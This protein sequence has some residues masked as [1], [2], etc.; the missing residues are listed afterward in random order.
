ME[1]DI[2][3]PK[4]I[5]KPFYILSIDGGGFRGLFAA[6]LLR[7]MEEEWQ[8]DWRNRFGLMA[9]TSTGAILA[10]GL[11]CEK[12]AVQLADFYTTHA[13]TIF[14]PRL[15]SRYD[16]LK[17]FTSRYSSKSLKT[18]LEATL[19][20]ITLGQL[21]IPL[22]L[23]AVDIGN[24]CVHVFKSKYHDNFVRDP[25]VRV[26]DAVLASCSAPTYFDPVVVDGKY[27]LVDGGLWANN[28]SLVAAID[29]QYRLKIPLEKVRVLSIGTGK[30]K[31]FYPRSQG[32][33]KDRLLGSWQGW[34]FL[35]RWQRSKFVDLIF[36]L[37]SDNAH[38]MLCLL[39]GESPLDSQQVLRLTFEADQPLP[40]DCVRKRDDW[41]TKADYIFTHNSPRIAA[42]LSI[43][44][45]APSC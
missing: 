15:R 23:P 13:E 33:W 38:N 1:P 34:G 25:N 4:S 43:Q 41:I 21:K 14:T 2:G 8:I 10:A 44:G 27:Q 18:L 9:G 6:H 45:S 29:V 22:I 30:S 42:F 20:E 5:S 31:T 3:E 28:P 7:R 26:S 24:G 12:S 32:K 36:N 37:Q 17:L 11:A 40:L 39:M 35:S 19:G 16:L